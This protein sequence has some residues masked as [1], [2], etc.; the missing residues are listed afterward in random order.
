MKTRRI[1]IFGLILA[2]SVTLAVSSLWAQATRPAP[3]Q[4]RARAQAERARDQA[5]RARSHVVMLEG[6]GPQI[7]VTVED[8]RTA[9]DATA[10]VGGG[11]RIA[12]VDPEGPAAKAG[13]REGDVVVAYDGERVRSARQFSRLVQETVA[14][15]TVNMAVV[16]D[17]AEQ[18]L[19]VTPEARSVRWDGDLVSRQ[20]ERRMRDL[21]PRLR[22]LE[23]RL[24][25]LEPRLR[26]FEF[27]G[28][29]AFDFDLPGMA[30][31]RGRLGVQLQTLTP[32]LAEYFGAGDGGVLISGVTDDSP[33]ARA[34]LRAGDVITAIDGDRVRSMDDVI[35]ELRDKEGDV[36]VG[37][38]RDKQE[39][40][41]T[42]TIE[43]RE[44]RRP[45]T[46]RP[47]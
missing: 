30:S 28:P 41:V 18:T 15:R 25:E 47:A 33:A 1:A 8:V 29:W 21:E 37:I 19:T 42:A 2:G 16:R 45:V 3:E 39:S 14:G 23:P 12:E 6:L 27:R 36:R 46:K 11:V 7:G 44:S 20:V 17:G 24:R 31:P 40:T 35:D 43:R 4:E 9:P 26:E 38:L 22:E 10:A 34:G 32:Q 13:V 5:E